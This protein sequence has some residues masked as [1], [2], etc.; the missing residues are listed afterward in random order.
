MKLTFRDV[1]VAYPGRET[2]ALIGVNIE[3]AAG[4]RVALVGRNGSGKSTLILTANGILR[5]QQGAVMLDGQPVQYDRRG[6][7]ALRRCVGVVFQDPDDQLFTANVYQDLSLGPLNLGLS[8]AEA[9]QRVL[10]AA[11]QCGLSHLLDRPTHSLSGGE[12]ARAAIAGVLAMTPRFLFV[13]EL[14]HHLDPWVRREVLRLLCDLASAGCAVVLA[15]HDWALVRTW[16]QHVIWLEA[17][18]IFRQGHP[19]AV[20]TGPECPDLEGA[21]C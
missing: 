11:E 8:Q 13:D 10:Q 12:K 19:S 9:R 4:Q 15:T 7:A 1:H 14:L 16:A 6:L 20:L 17:G 2:P 21:P 18:R 5:P 3:I